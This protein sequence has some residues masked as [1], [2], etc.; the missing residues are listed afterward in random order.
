M[1]I[2]YNQTSSSASSSALPSAS[3]SS[4]TIS[5]NDQVAIELIASWHYHLVRKNVEN[6]DGCLWM[7]QFGFANKWK[8][9]N[10][11]NDDVS[12]LN[13]FIADCF[14]CQCWWVK[15]TFIKEK[16]QMVNGLGVTSLSYYYFQEIEIE[17]STSEP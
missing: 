5:P 11:N 17:K 16:N 4:F 12:F 3:S 6:V 2:V 9:H 15:I 13:Q 14:Y 7:L 1:V 10:N 8:S